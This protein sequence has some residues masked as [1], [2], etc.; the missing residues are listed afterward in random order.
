[1]S[2]TSEISLERRVRCAQ[3]NLTL[4]SEDVRWVTGPHHAL[5]SALNDDA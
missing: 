5:M 2:A 3:R 4:S 1:M